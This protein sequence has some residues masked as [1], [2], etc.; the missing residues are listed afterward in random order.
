MKSIILSTTYELTEL[1]EL[2]RTLEMDVER[3]FVQERGAH[4]RFFLGTGKIEEVKEYLEEQEDIEA[5]VVNAELKPAQ[6]YYLERQLKKRVYDRINLILE[7]FTKNAH[8]REAKLQV[9]LAELNY[10]I[11]FIREY[12]HS[13]KKGEHP[14]FMS[15]GEYA[16]DD[17]TFS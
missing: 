11:P 17:Y 1:R 10:Q 15:G 5:V 3:I 2:M 4:P 12:I 8:S 9:E 7:I 13:A 14:G 16:V 6:L